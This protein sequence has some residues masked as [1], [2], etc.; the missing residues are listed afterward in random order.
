MLDRIT[1]S[2][3]SAVRIAL[4]GACVRA[5]MTMPRVSVSRVSAMSDVASMADVCAVS[6]RVCMAMMH[7]P[8]DSHDAEAHAA[9]GEAGEV[10]VKHT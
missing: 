8:A 9:D 1:V 5:P 4:V 6:G 10:Q 3:R 2:V 7:E